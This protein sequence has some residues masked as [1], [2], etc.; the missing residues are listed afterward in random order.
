MAYDCYSLQITEFNQKFF[1]GN[2]PYITT[3]VFV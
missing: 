1:G 2:V 3:V